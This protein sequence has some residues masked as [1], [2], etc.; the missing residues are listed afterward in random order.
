MS[1]QRAALAAAAA[2][3][4]WAAAPIQASGL[5]SI[6]L[7]GTWRRA[8]SADSRAA[9]LAFTPDGWANLLNG[10]GEQSAGDIAAQVRYRL[11]PPGDPRRIDFVTRRGNDLFAAGTTSWEITGYTDDSFT[12]R[13]KN[14]VEGS[15]ETW[16]RV[17]THRYFLTFAARDAMAGGESAAFVMWTTLDGKR[18]VLDGLGVVRRGSEARFAKIPDDIARAFATQGD[19]ARDAMMRIELSEAEYNRTRAV[20]RAWLGAV[21][22]RSAADPD[23]QAVLFIEATVESL[24]RCARRIQPA[25]AGV[26]PAVELVRTLRKANDRRH[27]SDRAFP[28]RW[29]PAD[30]S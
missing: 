6:E 29:K 20:H 15:L 3:A 25:G 1:R 22:R 7:V 2:L 16:A 12:A 8:D 24:N 14:S 11:E 18:T 28:V 13:A 9:L 17:Q 26:R 5:C 30:L 27:V 10:P 4:A 19:P 21:P 23:T